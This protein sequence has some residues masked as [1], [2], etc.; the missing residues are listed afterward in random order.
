MSKSYLVSDETKKIPIQIGDK[1]GILTVV[2]EGSRIGKYTR[3]FNCRCDCG[4]EKLVAMKHLRSGHS[5]SCGCAPHELKHG[6]T[7][8][9][10]HRIWSGMK[11]RCLNPNNSF[12][13]HYGGRGIYPCKKWLEFESFY[14][15]MGNRPSPRHS[16]NRKDND[17]HYNKK[18]CEWAT[19]VVQ[20][21]NTSR[22]TVTHEIAARIRELS[23][24]G[25]RLYPI[26]KI[27]GLNPGTVYNVIDR[28]PH[29]RT[30][31]N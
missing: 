28:R 13:K 20:K 22:N 27:V 29:R 4:I 2:S 17:G 19:S 1:Y 21:R 8:T 26:A 12:F 5:R 14:N 31:V 30:W 3:R 9:A 18:N 11:Q 23:A 10:E 16:L 25:L 15:D 7:G 24:S 6:K